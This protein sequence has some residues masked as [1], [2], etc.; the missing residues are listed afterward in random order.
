[1]LPLDKLQEYWTRLY[2]KTNHLNKPYKI[3]FTGGE[4]TINKDFI[5]FLDWLRYNYGDKIAQMGVTTNGSAS[6]SYYLKLFDYV[7]F[8]SFSTHTEHIN[9]EKFFDTANACNQYARKNHGKSF[10]V[11]IMEEFWAT[12][13]IE[14]YKK[15][16][17][18]YDIDFSISKIEYS[19]KTRDIPIFKNGVAL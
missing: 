6:T 18:E 7:N 11:N 16:C 8:I 3:S 2:E 9:E 19:Y 14:E 12:E 13:K 5:P 15:R 1:M 17:K 10:M 4:V